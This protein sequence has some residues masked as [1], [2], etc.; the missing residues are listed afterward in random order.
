MEEFEKTVK[1]DFN[2][3]DAHYNL[4]ILYARENMEEKAL[5]ELSAIKYLD[6]AF[7]IAKMDRKKN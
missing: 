5:R 3:F 1:F 7:D 4:L 6:P 2:H